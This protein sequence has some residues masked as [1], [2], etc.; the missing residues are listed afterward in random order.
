MR[1]CHGIKKLGLVIWVLLSAA[2]SHTGERKTD[3]SGLA[4]SNIL[5]IL[6]DDSMGKSDLDRYQ[7]PNIDRMAALGFSFQTCFATPVCQPSRVQL[8][9][10]KY[11]HKTGITNLERCYGWN[12]GY[13]IRN[14]NN[15]AR[16][17]KSAGY[18]TAIAGKWHVTGPNE[19]ALES[20]FDEYCLWAE[21]AAGLDSLLQHNEY[22]G[23]LY[24]DGPSRY[25]HPAIIRNGRFLKTTGDDYGPDIFCDFIIDFMRESKNKNRPF[26]AFY[27]MVL[28]HAVGSIEESRDKEFRRTEHI[29][30]TPDPENHEARI[31]G[32]PN[33]PL[34]VDHL[35]GRLLES[36]EE[37]DLAENT[38]VFFSCDN[39]SGPQGNGKRSST[40]RGCLVPM[41]VQVPG[42]GSA[43]SS[44]ALIDFTDVYPTFCEIA[45]VEPP[46]DIDG[47]S[48]LQVLEGGTGQ[49]DWIF[50]MHAGERVLRDTNWLLEENH[51]SDFGRFWF[52]SD[53]RQGR[54]TYKDV[55]HSTD[56]E[57]LFAK[58]RF[59]DILKHLPSPKGLPFREY[60][61]DPAF[62]DTT[63]R[64]T[65][66]KIPER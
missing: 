59:M 18:A 48:F 6:A 4:G 30:P 54:D 3:A 20:G 56:P 58:K 47:A 57:V 34:Y 1:G 25:W 11:G 37:M 23:K 45:G 13:Q 63:K 51:E 33:M 49:R 32:W 61:P 10:G 60:G 39:G 46:G 26:L 22:S 17:L 21:G 36:L 65:T 31:Y 66:G 24:G 42:K 16:S 40:E 19:D 2:C 15:F 62:L 28:P 27:S 55:T 38:L 43:V 12:P 50:S 7:T 64:M 5:F 41:I 14:E 29:P 44:P 53:S 35:V 8:L 52:C 9:S